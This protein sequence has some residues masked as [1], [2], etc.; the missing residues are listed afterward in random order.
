LSA[1]EQPS[2]PPRANIKALSSVGGRYAHIDAMRAVAVMLVVVAHTEIGGIPGGSGVTIFFTISGFII[3]LLLLNERERTGG[4]NVRGFYVR[5][6]FKLFP[7]FLVIVLVPTAVYWALGNEISWPYVGA[8]TFFIF[9]WAT[10]LRPFGPIEILPG[11]SVVWS[12]SIEEQFYIVFALIWL[13]LV[14][15]R[16]FF[17]L[18]TATA[19]AAIVLPLALRLVLAAGGGEAVSER[20]YWGTDTRLDAIAIGVIAA[21]AYK[22]FT[23]GRFPIAARVLAHP[24]W[25]VI[26]PTVY[27][28]TVIFRDEWFR[29]TFRFT[30][31]ASV[32]AVVILW[33]LLD[34]GSRLRR[35]FSAVTN[36]RIVQI[37]G[38][39]SYSIYLAHAS[40]NALVESWTSRLPRAA[41][42]PLLIVLGSATGIVAWLLLERPAE[43]WKRRLM[44]SAAPHRVDRALR[45]R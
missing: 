25:I 23:V 15:R 26:A 17:P 34:T 20:I 37:V 42:V 32:A 28:G 40:V 16:R 22:A 11:S 14:A 43:R 24:S 31:Q 41:E 13:A 27:L 33:G 39:A 7:P 21:I 3:T 8:Q 18:I 44:A 35:L 1:R 10:L 12:L 5:R 30:L 9:N 6:L 38:L 19:V 4:F 36:V 45:D 2:S 29:D